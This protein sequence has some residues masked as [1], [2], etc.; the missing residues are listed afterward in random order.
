VG[1]PQAGSDLGLP[2]VVFPSRA[3]LPCWLPYTPTR[4]GLLPRGLHCSPARHVRGLLKLPRAQN[5]CACARASLTHRDLDGPRQQ[6]LPHLHRSSG[7]R[8]PSSPL[9]LPQW[10]PRTVG[11]GR[12]RSAPAGRRAFPTFSLRLCPCV[13]GPLPRQLVECLDPFLPPRQRPAPRSARIG[14]PQRSYSD[15][16][17]APFSRLQSL[18][19]VQAHRCARP[20]DR[21]YRYGVHR[22]AAVTLPSEPLV[23]CYLPTPR[24]G[25]PSASGH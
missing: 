16:R 3:Q 20:P 8:R 19:S 1:F 12:V 14:A 22:L 7:L 18:L 9:P 5:P 6:G 10:S 24:I 4:N 21:S 17:T 25:V 13:L 23:G 11:L 15:C 2:A